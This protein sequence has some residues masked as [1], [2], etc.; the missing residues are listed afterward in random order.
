[1]VEL[2]DEAIQKEEP[3]EKSSLT[4]TRMSKILGYD[5][6]SLTAGNSNYLWDKAFEVAK[7]HEKTTKILL[8]I[9]LQWRIASDKRKWIAAVQDSNKL[10]EDGE[11]ITYTTYWIKP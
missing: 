3:S 8:G 4:W 10:N 7:G 1:M 5:S 9:M 11:L 2:F 6:Q